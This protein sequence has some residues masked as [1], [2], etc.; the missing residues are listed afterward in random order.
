ML[1][2]NDGAKAPRMSE[3]ARLSSTLDRDERDY[4]AEAWED[5]LAHRARVKGRRRWRLWHKLRD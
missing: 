2:V 1:R 3:R 5:L 4:R